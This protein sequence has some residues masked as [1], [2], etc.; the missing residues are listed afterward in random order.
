MSI[1]TGDKKIS[2]RVDGKDLV[3][4]EDSK[5]FLPMK[6]PEDIPSNLVLEYGNPFNSG[7]G[8]SMTLCNYTKTDNVLIRII[9]G[10]YEGI[11]IGMDSIL[12]GNN[13]R[14]SGIYYSNSH[15]RPEVPSMWLISHRSDGIYIGNTR[16]TDLKGKWLL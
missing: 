4:N 16:V 8:K 2:L 15:D 1:A 3:L 11:C 14:F 9:D 7:S 5:S 10:S 12:E 6:N 13:T